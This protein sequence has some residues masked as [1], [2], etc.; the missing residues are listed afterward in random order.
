MLFALCAVAQVGWAAAAVVRPSR[1]VAAA[2][3]VLN[4]G[5]LAAWAVSRRTE[6]VGVPDLTAAVLAAV[7]VAGARRRRRRPAAPARAAGP[8]GRRGGGAGG[9]GHPGDGGGPRAR[10]RRRPRP[11]RGHDTA[12]AAGAATGTAHDAEHDA[13]HDAAASSEAAGTGHEHHD[14]P[15]RLDHEPTDEQREAARRL[16]DET[17]AA[18][19][20]YA[21]VATA[22]GAGYRSIGDAAERR[23]STTSTPRSP[24]TAPSSTRPGPSPSST[25]CRPTAA[26]GSPP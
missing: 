20:V 13:E 8:G 12:L 3:V 24:P 11:R 16:I 17:E 14:V 19:A 18:T 26:C 23:S 5:A 9:A 7:A 22:T 21:D 15:E 10:R 25:R 4:A 6:A 2:G 1:R